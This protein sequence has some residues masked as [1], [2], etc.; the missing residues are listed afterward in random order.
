MATIRNL[1]ENP[2]FDK[3][4]FERMNGL[5]LLRSFGQTISD[6]KVALQEAF[7][8]LYAEIESNLKQKSLNEILAFLNELGQPDKILENES[9]YTDVLYIKTCLEFPTFNDHSLFVEHACDLL[10]VKMF[11]HFNQIGNQLDFDSFDYSKYDK[12]THVKNDITTNDRNIRTLY[13]FVYILNELVFN[14]VRLSIFFAKPGL[15]YFRS[16]SYKNCFNFF[17]SYFSISLV[18]F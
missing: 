12:L 15:I 6:K 10:F 7:E 2:Y 8:L 13:Y 11:L 9:V 3:L 18:K 5:S 14:S 4:E 1:S 17:V 16:F